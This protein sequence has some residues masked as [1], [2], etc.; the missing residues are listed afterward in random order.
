MV[1]DDTRTYS[2][3]ERNHDWEEHDI[4][5]S[6]ANKQSI[7]GYNRVFRDG[8]RKVYKTANNLTFS[9]KVTTF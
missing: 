2:F 3:L 4:T 9:S 7:N 1:E 5:E 6:E 8:M